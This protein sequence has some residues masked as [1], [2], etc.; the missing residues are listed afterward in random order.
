LSAESDVERIAAALAEAARLREEGETEASERVLDELRAGLA[1]LNERSFRGALLQIEAGE[2]WPAEETLLAGIILQRRFAGL[3][4]DWPI[5]QAEHLAQLALIYFQRGQTE[6][7]SAAV[8]MA[9]PGYLPFYPSPVTC[10]IAVLDA[11][12]QSVFGRKHNGTF[13]EVGAFDGESYS[14]T[15]GLADLGWRGLY[16]EPIPENAERCRQ[17]H[18]R[19][20][21]IDVETIAIGAE[22]RMIEL[23]V[24]G[25]FTRAIEN[26]GK[27]EGLIVQ[28]R[29]RRLDDVLLEHGIAAGFD[30]LVVDVEGHEPGVFAG[31]ELER[32]R[33]AMMIVELT[34]EPSSQA[35]LRRIVS[36]GYSVLYRDFINT[37]FVASPA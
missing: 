16:L 4:A 34:D 12:Y 37:V 13:V 6:A 1:H 18:G 7:A 17:R 27:I 23:S 8:A 19:N 14:N 15:S 31:F 20:Q 30:L 22:E 26:D 21:K 9:E 35:L 2:S 29:Q 25:P 33:P 24:S 5:S 32:W 11:L 3:L 10:Q 36:A 28:A